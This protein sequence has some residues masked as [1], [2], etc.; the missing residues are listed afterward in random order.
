MGVYRGLPGSKVGVDSAVFS[1]GGV[2][3]GA[4]VFSQV[5]CTQGFD[6]EELQEF[7]SAK[8]HWALSF[9]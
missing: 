1:G 7:L 3:V 4:I 5:T 8:L 9:S 6:V 2:A